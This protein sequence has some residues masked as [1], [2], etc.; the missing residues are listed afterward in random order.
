[1]KHEQV[2][3]K[4]SFIEWSQ[5]QSRLTLLM[6]LT[7]IIYAM[8]AIGC[9]KVDKPHT[10]ILN[11]G[12]DLA[13][14]GSV[15]VDIVAVSTDDRL[16]SDLRELSPKLGD[17]F[18]ANMKA[19]NTR[20]LLVHKQLK[21]PTD[22]TISANQAEP[23]IIEAEN[24]LF[25]DLRKARNEKKQAGTWRLIVIADLPDVTP[26]SFGTFHPGFRE[27][28]LDPLYWEDG[29]IELTINRSSISD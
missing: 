9:A 28:S 10:I 24:E 17:Y 5:L 16:I 25:E 15:Q 1:M 4:C 26:G 12:S 22:L 13:G 21:S 23:R 18:T 20:K 2:T 7:L 6:S 19:N 3:V 29:T 8:L 14:E 27:F 11:A